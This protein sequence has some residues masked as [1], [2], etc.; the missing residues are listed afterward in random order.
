MSEKERKDYEQT[1]NNI[2]HLLSIRTVT[3]DDCYMR[4]DQE[5]EIKVLVDAYLKLAKAGL[6]REIDPKKTPPEIL[7][8]L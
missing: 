4:N 7:E 1:M 5:D 2:V 6:L 8:Q 3:E